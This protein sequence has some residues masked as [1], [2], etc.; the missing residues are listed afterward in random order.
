MLDPIR[1]LEQRRVFLEGIFEVATACNWSDE[2]TAELLDYL[3][4]SLV[5]IDNTMFDVY[6]KT[7]DPE[8]ARDIW[9]AKMEGLRHWL[10]TIF[11]VKIRYV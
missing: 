8:Q 3:W 2:D 1:I 9:E 5:E 10:T 4:D 7:Q 11:G 6:V